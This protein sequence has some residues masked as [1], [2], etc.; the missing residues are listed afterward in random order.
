MEN[1]ENILRS[2]VADQLRADVKHG[3]GLQAYYEDSI[4]FDA[5]QLWPLRV[6]LG[7]DKPTL[8][9]N[10]ESDVDN[11]I[12]LHSYLANL[13]ETQ[14]SDK[15]LWTYLAHVSFREYTK[16][17]WKLPYSLEEINSDPAKRKK[18]I[19]SVLSHWFLSGTDSR[20]LRRHA[21]ARLWWA[22]HLTVAP[23]E[24]EAGFEGLESADRY[25]Y[26]KILLS[27]EDLYSQVLERVLGTSR[28]VLIAILEYFS[29]HPSQVARPVLRSM[30]KELNLVSGIKRLPLLTYEENFKVVEAVGQEAAIIPIKIE[31]SP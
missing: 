17:R 20:A 21:L 9:P 3:I 5:D 13:D 19:D 6:E 30:M 12:L 23:W 18:V 28:P 10:R 31:V 1:K 22:A 8:A 16:N 11:A 24:R 25:K 26:T 4:D 27:N 15:R 2:V 29:Q 7:G 14:A